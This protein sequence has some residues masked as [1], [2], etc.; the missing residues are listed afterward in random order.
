MKMEL[1]KYK[2]EITA[3]IRTLSKMTEKSPFFIDL[4]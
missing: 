3:E 1:K 4:L 2:V